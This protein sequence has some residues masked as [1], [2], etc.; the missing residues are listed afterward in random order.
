[1]SKRNWDTRWS[2]ILAVV[3][4]WSED[5]SSKYA[6]VIV[7]GRQ[8]LRSTGFNGIPE[9]I[10]LEPSYHN[11]PDK[12]NYFVH[13]EINAILNSPLSVAGCTMYILKS[14]CAQCAGAIINSGITT[15]KYLKHHDLNERQALEIDNWRMSI[16]DAEAMIHEAGIRM[17]QVGVD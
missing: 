4:E 12:Y 1:V 5:T 9:G 8:R 11:R 10:K 15:I 13:A 16:E 14:P 17:V 6:A 3:S 2:K 7:D